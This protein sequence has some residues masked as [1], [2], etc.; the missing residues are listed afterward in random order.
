[1]SVFSCFSFSFFELLHFLK[2]RT[3]FKVWTYFRFE[4]FSNL[5]FFEFWF[6]FNFVHILN[7]SNLNFCFKL[8]FVRN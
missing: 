2:Y 6:F 1:L 4:H 7:C 8:K 3:F 5:N